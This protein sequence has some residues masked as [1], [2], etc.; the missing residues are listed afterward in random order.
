MRDA[1]PP[2]DDTAPPP[3]ERSV[4]VDAAASVAARVV[5]T[6]IS[7]ISGIIVAASLDLTHYGAYSLAAGLVGLLNVA[8][9][10]GTT[11]ALARYLAQGRATPRLVAAVIATR[12]LLLGTGA[13]VLL[14]IWLVDPN[15]SQFVHLL[16]PAALLLF[17]QGL[18]AFLY[19]SLPSMRRIRLLLL[20]TV[21]QPA[22]ELV[23]VLLAR[24]HGAT[25]TQMLLA[26]AAGAILAVLVGYLALALSHRGMRQPAHATDA[27][28]HLRDVLHYG[29]RLFLVLLLLMVIGQ[30]DQFVIAAFHSAADVAPYAL[31]IKLQA[32]LTA[33]AITAVAVVAPRIAG[34]GAQGAAMYRQWLTFV[35]VLYAGACTVF[36]V[37]APDVFEAINP[38]YRDQAGV[39]AALLPFIFL[40]SVAILPSVTLNQIGHAGSR[41]RLALVALA[42]NGV[43]DL[44]L[45][46]PLGAY[47]AAVG[48]TAAFAYYALAHHRLV[49]AAL[50]ATAPAG[51]R[52][53][54]LA[55]PVVRGLVLAVAMGALALALHPLAAVIGPN[56]GRSHAVLVLAIAAGIPALLHTAATARLVRS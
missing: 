52:P 45:V 11:S 26:A 54:P 43:L 9:D 50:L 31:A 2:H 27:P 20:V 24:A 21:L 29:R 18:V 36:A 23:G 28:A 38:A 19:G 3:A 47:G 6:G 22:L 12:A 10:L 33:P 7:A 39:L 42:I 48:T 30:L 32:M 34:A 49:D 25:A 56:S 15:A 53:A 8:L 4:A 46:P 14:G 55:P 16:A 1:D 35:I 13:F 40:S 41:L 17:A 44:S 51:S 5:A 37:L